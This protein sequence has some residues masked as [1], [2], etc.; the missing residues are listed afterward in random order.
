M[1]NLNLQRLAVVIY[2][3]EDPA[4]RS[5]PLVLV[6]KSAILVISDD[7]SKKITLTIK[8]ETTER[9]LSSLRNKK[10]VA[11]NTIKI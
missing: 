2:Q 6:G 3:S 8:Y 7:D 11:S 9:C 5:G 1:F 10:Q 4:S